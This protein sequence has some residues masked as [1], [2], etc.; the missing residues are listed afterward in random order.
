MKL[1][2]QGEMWL[3]KRICSNGNRLRWESSK[4]CLFRFFL[5]SAQHSF[6]LGTGQNTCAMSILWPTIRQVG[7][8]I[9]LWPTPTQEGGGRWDISEPY[10]LLWGRGSSFNDPPWRKGVLVSRTAFGRVKEEP[11]TG[12]Q[13]KVRILDS[14]TSCK[15]CQSALVQSTQH[16]KAPYFGV[17]WSELQQTRCMWGVPTPRNSAGLQFP[18]VAN[19]ASYNLAQFSPYLEL[20]THITGW[21]LSPMRLS[22]PPM[23]IPS[24]GCASD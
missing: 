14:E 1:E 11:E 4:T 21:G 8:R 9:S 19:W 2:Q 3:D 15:T 18:V 5:N 13:D 6:L 10:G 24:P 12:K 20:V 22:P 16:A 23:P 17:L 7:Q